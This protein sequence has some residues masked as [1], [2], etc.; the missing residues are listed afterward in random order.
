MLY[1]ATTHV[2]PTMISTDLITREPTGAFT[3]Q[4][5]YSKV[6]EVFVFVSEPRTFGAAE[7][8]VK[9]TF[10]YCIS[11]ASTW[12][13]GRGDLCSDIIDDVCKHQS[14]VFHICIILNSCI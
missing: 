5:L 7:T 9:L 6:G 10:R 12:S 1:L 3:E 4:P 8:L 2:I 13:V 14:T 11:E